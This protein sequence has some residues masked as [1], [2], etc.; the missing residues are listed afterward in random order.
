MLSIVVPYLLKPPLRKQADGC[1]ALGVLP[2]FPADCVFL[3]FY[4]LDK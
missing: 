1:E 4:N 2:I 3:K